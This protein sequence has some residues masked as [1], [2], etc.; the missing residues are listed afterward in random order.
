MTMMAVLKAVCIAI[1]IGMLILISAMACDDTSRI[2]E[3][4]M[5][6]GV[7]IMLIAWASLII[8]TIILI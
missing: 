7:W 6:I 5:L 8:L 2:S 4:G 1:V 3:I